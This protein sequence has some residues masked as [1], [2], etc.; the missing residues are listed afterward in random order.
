[1]MEYNPALRQYYYSTTRTFITQYYY[2]I[3]TIVIQHWYNSMTIEYSAT[4]V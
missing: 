4:T 2:S 3:A 1:M